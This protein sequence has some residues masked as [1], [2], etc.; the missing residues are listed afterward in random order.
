MQNLREQGRVPIARTPRV[1]RYNSSLLLRTVHRRTTHQ[2]T[3]K[4]HISA[5][6]QRTLTRQGKVVGPPDFK[7]STYRT[8]RKD[9][10]KSVNLSPVA[11]KNKGITVDPKTPYDIYRELHI[12][13]VPSS[14]TRGP[15]RNEEIVRRTNKRAGRVTSTNQISSRVRPQVRNS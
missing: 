4:R 14:T 5:V 12:F 15:I 1:R 7:A 6:S 2:R 10:R 3:E 11:F 13:K 8:K 9:R